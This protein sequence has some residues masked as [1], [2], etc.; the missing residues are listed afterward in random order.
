MAIHYKFG[1]RAAHPARPCQRPADS[2][3]AL[4]VEFNAEGSSGEIDSVTVWVSG[5]R[6]RPHERRWVGRMTIP[7]LRL[8]ATQI[9]G[10][11]VNEFRAAA[12]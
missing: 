3:G 12:A 9:A 6:P 2:R 4:N 10:E 1:P 8:L 11:Y 5:L 7:Q